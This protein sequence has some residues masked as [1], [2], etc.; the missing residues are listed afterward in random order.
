MSE[1]LF[2]P[3]VLAIPAVSEDRLCAA[4]VRILP[5]TMLVLDIADSAEEATARG[6]NEA[7]RDG[8]QYWY[9]CFTQ[10]DVAKVADPVF[11]M[12]MVRHEFSRLVKA[13]ATFPATVP[14]DGGG[15]GF[16]ISPR[17]YVLTNYHL[18]TTDVAN[19]RR[20]AGALH[21]EV[22]CRGLRAQIATKRGSSGWTWSDAQEVW[23]VSN[24]PADR[25]LWADAQ[26]LLHPR[27]DTALLRVFP[28]PADFVSLSAAV[29]VVGDPVWMAGFPLRT[30]RAGASPA[31]IG[32]ADA[33]GT[34]RVSAG[35][36]TETEP[37]NYFTTDLD[38]SMGN[39][40]SPVFDAAGGVTGMFSRAK[41][42]GPRNAVEYGFVQRV[43]VTSAM[44]R[45]SLELH[46]EIESGGANP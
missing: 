3:S 11:S 15:T 37:P 8:T 4:I 38:G 36:I 42:E 28:P 25:A 10:D 5:K 18:I 35:K 17:G 20:E 27:E 29:P 33:D 21:R 19:H 6:R 14:L 31:S 16:A 46:V 2:H 9:R 22:P 34:L 12:G 40:G 30:A 1:G 23:L 39:S 45:R 7:D 44:A 41:G 26:G 13:G 32:Y 24:P 43:H